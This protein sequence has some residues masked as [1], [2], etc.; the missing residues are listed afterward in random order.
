MHFRNRSQDLKISRLESNFNKK[1]LK[2]PVSSAFALYFQLSFEFRHFAEDRIFEKTDTETDTDS[3]NE[4]DRDLS[5]P[6]FF[7]CLPHDLGG[8]A[9]AFLVCVGVHAESHSL[10]AVPQGL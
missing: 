9:D 4:P 5:L 3:K 6:G 10:V 7:Y 8:L 1:H 2:L